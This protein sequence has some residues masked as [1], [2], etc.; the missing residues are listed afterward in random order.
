MPYE[1]LFIYQIYY[2]NSADSQYLFLRWP[3]EGNCTTHRKISLLCTSS[4]KWPGNFWFRNPSRQRN[5]RSVLIFQR[6]L[7][8]WSDPT[9]GQRWKHY[10]LWRWNK[11]S[12][13]M[14]KR[15]SRN[16]QVKLC[17][18]L[19]CKRAFLKFNAFSKNNSI[20]IVINSIPKILTLLF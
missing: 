5:T 11:V 3:R 16:N 6:F 4:P 9:P 13:Q 18:S 20:L 2:R 8:M 12:T 17:P 10:L 7:S 15:F 1:T 14:T 19:L